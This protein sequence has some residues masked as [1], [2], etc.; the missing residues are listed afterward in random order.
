MMPRKD[1]SRIG[2]L[3]PDYDGWMAGSQFIRMLCHSLGNACHDQGIDVY[4]LR[5]KWAGA[6]SLP[7]RIESLDP[8]HYW[9]GERFLRRVLFL[10]ER[11]VLLES[12]LKHGLS[13]VLPLRRVG[14]KSA[15]VKA[16]GWIPDFQ[17]VLLPEFF[18]EKSCRYRNT[19]FRLLAERCN[20]LMLSSHNALEHFADFAPD[21]AD[22][23]RVASFPSLYAYELPAGGAE[24][25]RRKFNLPEKFALVA[26]QFWRHKNHEV[27]IDAIGLLRRKGIIIHVVMTGMPVDSRDPTNETLSRILQQIASAGLN[28]QIRILGMLRFDDLANLMRTAAVVIQPSRF[29]GWSSVVQDGKALGRPIICSDIPVHREQAPDALGFFP[30]DSAALLAELLAA[31]WQQLEP[32]PDPVV[33]ASALTAEREFARVHGQRLLSICREADSL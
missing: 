28:E 4:L 3:E 32:G 33:E 13:V 29:E 2:V 7:A 22:K 15:N 25:A 10:R 5:E 12:A 19:A 6:A 11:S 27:V 30:C 20:L 21:Y 23:G 31:N 18:S 16:I 24:L 14:F 8:P 1:L 26:N 9:Y 17:H